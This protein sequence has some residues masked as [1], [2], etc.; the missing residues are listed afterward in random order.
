[1]S[2]A[3]PAGLWAPLAGDLPGLGLTGPLYL[4]HT[5]ISPNL[6]LARVSGVFGSFKS[7]AFSRG[8][9]GTKSTD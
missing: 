8:A 4:I 7:P 3:T 1:M 5:N 9:D 6:A 2:R